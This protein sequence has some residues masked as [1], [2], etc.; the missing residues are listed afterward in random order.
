M[1]RDELRLRLEDEGR[2]AAQRLTEASEEL[3]DIV[4]AARY[5]NID[6]EHDPEGSTIAYERARVTALVADA[7]AHL[8]AIDHAVERLD[9]G[10]HGRCA[11][12]GRPISTTRL[13]AL[14]SADR[15]VTCAA[16]HPKG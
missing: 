3:A 14:P 10:E 11:V 7:R 2:Q 9:A 8:S 16:G 4:T 15:C 5:A 1:Q 12:C 6:D 13:R